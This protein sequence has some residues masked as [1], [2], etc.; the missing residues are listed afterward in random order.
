MRRK[1]AILLF[2]LLVFLSIGGAVFHQNFYKGKRPG[3][4]EI[5]SFLRNEIASGDWVFARKQQT[6]SFHIV[7]PAW[8]N[9]IGLRPKSH[10]EMDLYQFN[11]LLTSGTTA[12]AIWRED[13][14]VV[15]IQY[16]DASL[17]STGFQEILCRRFPVLRDPS[18][19][20]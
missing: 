12:I 11:N 4:S 14:K 9:K 19:N 15:T 10:Y 5:D 1:P 17:V 20:P 6:N 3:F 8:W 16:G 7:K 13:G 2:V 18:F